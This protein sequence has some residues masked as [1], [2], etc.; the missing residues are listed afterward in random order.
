MLENASDSSSLVRRPFAQRSR[1]QRAKVT[2][3]PR[4]MAIDGRTPL[5]RRLRDV[6]DQLADGLGGWSALS[7]LQAASV[8][9]SAELQALAEDARA[10]KLNGAT[11]VTLDDLVRLDRLAEQSVRRLGLDRKR[12]RAA[13]DLRA[14]FRAAYGLRAGE[15]LEAD[16]AI[17]LTP[18]RQVAEAGT[19]SV[20]DDATATPAPHAPSGEE[21]G[22]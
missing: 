2:N 18:L 21:A 12:E 5:G 20:I 19:D 4:R 6:A 13:P 1:N 16:A 10:R 22:P 11:D 17:P 14:Q 7:D 15:E 3:N 9:K 8:R